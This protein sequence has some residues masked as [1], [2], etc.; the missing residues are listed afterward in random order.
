M[1]T[2]TELVW[3]GKYDAKGNRVAPL[4]VALPFQTIETA[5]ESAQV[6]SRNLFQP[7]EQ[8]KPW[9]NRLIWGH[10][11]YVLASL[12]AKLAGKGNLINV[13][14]EAGPLFYRKRVTTR[15]R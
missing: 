1:P 3:D 15:G 9:R 10:K 6:R 2:K 7:V 14:H 12:L 4:R 13:R 5:N 8:D 11:K